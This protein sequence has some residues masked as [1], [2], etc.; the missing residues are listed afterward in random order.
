[1]CGLMAEIFNLEAVN[2]SNYLWVSRGY[3]MKQNEV[4]VIFLSYSIDVFVYGNTVRC[5]HPMYFQNTC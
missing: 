5:E 3:R 4:T 2:A 1:M